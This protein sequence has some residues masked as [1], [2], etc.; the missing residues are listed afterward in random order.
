MHNNNKNKTCE[1]ILNVKLIYNSERSETD[2]GGTDSTSTVDSKQT[3]RSQTKVS[4]YIQ[5]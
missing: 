5:K 4:R 3:K 2:G 1:Q